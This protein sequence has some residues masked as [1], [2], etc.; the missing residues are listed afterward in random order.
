VCKER[1]I[2]FGQAGHGAQIR[3]KPLREIAKLYV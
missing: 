2:A 1:M 3:A